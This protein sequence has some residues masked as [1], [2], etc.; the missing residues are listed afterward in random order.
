MIIEGMNTPEGR[1]AEAKYRAANR[2]AL[3]NECG[4]LGRAFCW[5]QCGSFLLPAISKPV[6]VAL[7]C[8][9]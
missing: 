3:C 7:P 5:C 9:C 1:A 2:V 8:W 6:Q 4:S